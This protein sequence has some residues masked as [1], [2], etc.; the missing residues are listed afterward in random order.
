MGAAS[1]RTPTMTDVYKV[2]AYVARWQKLALWLERKPGMTTPA[3]WSIPDLPRP[4]KVD[5]AV[6]QRM[7]A[8]RQAGENEEMERHSTGFSHIR[9]IITHT[10]AG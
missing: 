3:D 6:A 2:V 8:Q 9:L 10:V 4:G 5:R 1:T 7:D